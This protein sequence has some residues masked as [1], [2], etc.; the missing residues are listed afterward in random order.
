MIRRLSSVRLLPVTIFALA[1]LLAV[2]SSAI[3]L[4]PDASD[5]RERREIQPKMRL[6]RR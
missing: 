5:C 1:S 4:S 3:R 2:K 6:I